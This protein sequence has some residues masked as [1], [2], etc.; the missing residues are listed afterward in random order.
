MRDWIQ[1]LVAF[2]HEDDS[3]VLG[4][5]LIDEMKVATPDGR[6]EVL[7]DDRWD[8]LTRLGEAFARG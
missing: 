8:T 3:Y 1:I 7:K 6:I 4:T 5:K 2:V